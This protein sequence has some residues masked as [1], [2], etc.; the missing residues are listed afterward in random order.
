MV[1]ELGVRLCLGC[2]INTSG[3]TSIM[4]AIDF[5]P[6]AIILGI[7]PSLVFGWLPVPARSARSGIAIDLE[8]GAIS[9]LRWS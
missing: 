9:R 7:A 2:I 6:G 4:G 3:R 8:L 1:G 5:D